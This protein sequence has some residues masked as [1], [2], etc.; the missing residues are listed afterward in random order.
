[1]FVYIYYYIPCSSSVL[2]VLFGNRLR[3]MDYGLPSASTY[4]NY[5]AQR[6]R[7]LVIEHSIQTCIV[8]SLHRHGFTVDILSETLSFTLINEGGYAAS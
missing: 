2:V 1:M 6:L 8:T 3:F 7:L 5:I 4:L